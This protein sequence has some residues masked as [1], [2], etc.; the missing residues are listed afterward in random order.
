ML[1]CVSSLVK[2]GTKPAPTSAF[3]LSFARLFGVLS[4]GFARNHPIRIFRKPGGWYF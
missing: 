1:F 4:E 3:F 2:A